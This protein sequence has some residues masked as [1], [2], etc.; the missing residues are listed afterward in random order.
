MSLIIFTAPA[1][2]KYYESMNYSY[3]GHIM[4][5]YNYVASI[6]TPMPI[7]RWRHVYTAMMTSNWKRNSNIIRVKDNN[8]MPPPA[9]EGESWNNI[10]LLYGGGKESL[11]SLC[12]LNEI[13]DKPI[14]VITIGARWETKEIVNRLK[15]LRDLHKMKI[16]IHPAYLNKNSRTWGHMIGSIPICHK[17]KIGSLIIGTELESNS[18]NSKTK[19]VTQYSCVGVHGLKF[20]T[21]SLYEAGYPITISSIVSPIFAWG[22]LYIL[23]HRYPKQ[24][25]YLMSYPPDS[26]YKRF[27]GLKESYSLIKKMRTIVYAESMGIKIDPHQDE[28][29][30]MIKKGYLNVKDGVKIPKGPTGVT[31]SMQFQH[32]LF[33][34]HMTK[35]M[36]QTSFLESPAINYKQ[37]LPDEFKDQVWEIIEESSKGKPFVAGHTHGRMTLNPDIGYE[38]LIKNLLTRLKIGR[39]VDKAPTLEPYPTVVTPVT[40]NPGVSRKNKSTTQNFLDK[41]GMKSGKIK[42]L[43]R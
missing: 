8:R 33:C 3:P 6:H 1:R 2:I 7:V 21:D 19:K 23:S 35:Y 27:G 25:K 9:K 40:I 31:T 15:K 12:M 32:A 30:R 26:Y 24:L 28:V 16:I 34:L 38:G 18:I 14:H 22:C 39:T 37:F 13:T 4:N 5:P 36:K 29:I 10:G 20:A 41:H 42:G 43:K 11:L 17:Y